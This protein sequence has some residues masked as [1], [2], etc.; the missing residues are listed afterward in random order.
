MPPVCFACLQPL[1]HR[2]LVRLNIVRESGSFKANL[3]SC[4][5]AFKAQLS[6]P[7]H[8]EDEVEL[9]SRFMQAVDELRQ[10][11]LIKLSSRSRGCI[12]RL[13]ISLD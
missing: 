12:E 6:G 3:S 11:G 1:A 7:D 2:S 4:L 5:T 10:L 8:M 13:C 9:Q